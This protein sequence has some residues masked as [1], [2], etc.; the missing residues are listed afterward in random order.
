MID[1]QRPENPPVVEI[2]AK[3]DILARNLLQNSTEAGDI[4]LDTP[5]VPSRSL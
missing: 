4:L 3:R 2:Q 1:P 5:T